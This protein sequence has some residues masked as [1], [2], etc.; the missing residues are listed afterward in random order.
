MIWREDW[1]GCH[2][3]V[4]QC[5]CLARTIRCSGLL[6]SVQGKGGHGSRQSAS[7]ADDDARKGVP[8][9]SVEMAKTDYH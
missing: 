2:I 7:A 3:M 6:T 4:Q 1:D 5:N 9:K 8:A